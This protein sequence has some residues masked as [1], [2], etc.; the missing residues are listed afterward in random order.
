MPSWEFPKY[1][2]LITQLRRELHG[3][4]I[5]KK[6]D[7]A[8]AWFVERVRSLNGQINRRQLLADWNLKI[9]QSP[10][11]GRLYLF[12]YDPKLKK[13]LPYYDRFPLIIMVGPAEGGFYGLNLHY[14]PPLVRAAFL[15]RLI[16]VSLSNK[17][18]ESAKLD[19]SYRMLKRSS[20][21]A[22][23]APCFKHYLW[24]HVK[25]PFSR[26]DYSDWSIAIFLPTEDFAK[27]TKQAVWQDS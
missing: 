16:E 9:R 12:V 13:E 5:N 19:I 10:L 18:S 3:L 20:T 24:D 11:L 15:D 8:R 26:V 21:L 23:F 1:V 22:P 6:S 4:G 7:R 2:S 14:L 25:T 17:L 27:A